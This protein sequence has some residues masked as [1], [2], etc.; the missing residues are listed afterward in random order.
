MSLAAE[1]PG[2]AGFG[3]DLVHGRIIA[4][5]HNIRNGGTQAGPARGRKKSVR[6]S[7]VTSQLMEKKEFF[8]NC[9]AT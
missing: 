5:L 3:V 2:T 1:A 4:L 7:D 8:R 9:G 6:V